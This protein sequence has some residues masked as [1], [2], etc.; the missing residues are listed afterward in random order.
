MVYYIYIRAQ[1]TAFDYGGNGDWSDGACLNMRGGLRWVVGKEAGGFSRIFV[2]ACAGAAAAAA[3]V[4]VVVGGGAAATAVA[5]AW[6][7]DPRM[8]STNAAVRLN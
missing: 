1:N 2:V 3:V 4:V 6:V 7:R 8:S 5:A